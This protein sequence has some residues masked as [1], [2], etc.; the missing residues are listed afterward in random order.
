[1]KHLTAQLP[2]AMWRELIGLPRSQRDDMFIALT[3]RSR[4]DTT[5]D[6]VTGELVVLIDDEPF[7]ETSVDDLL[8]APA[9]EP[10]EQ[11]VPA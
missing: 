4:T 11:P 3:D 2:V 9:A 10:V 1:M 5:F 7:V 8:R 6:P